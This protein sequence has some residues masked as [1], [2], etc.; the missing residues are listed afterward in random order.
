MDSAGWKPKMQDMQEGPY[1]K[2]RKKS[3]AGLFAAVK[4]RSEMYC[5]TQKLVFME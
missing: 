5:W 1:P 4:Y 3:V 2:K